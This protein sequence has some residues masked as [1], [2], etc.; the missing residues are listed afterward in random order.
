MTPKERRARLFADSKPI[1]RHAV[2]DDAKWTWVSQELDNWGGVTEGIDRDNW[3]SYAMDRLA[4][5]DQVLVIEDAN[6]QFASG[7]GPVC[8]VSLMSNGWVVEPHSHW[9]AWATPRN[10]LRGTVEFLRL[11]RNSRAVG[12]VHLKCGADDAKWFKRIS[13]RYN[14]LYL[15][16]RIP[17]GQP[18][19]DEYLFYLRGSK[20]DRQPNGQ[21]QERQLFRSRAHRPDAPSV[22]AIQHE[23]RNHTDLG[24]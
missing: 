22:S 4:Q 7:H 15:V 17:H 18:S 16:G 2:L 14:P 9:L 23:R 6:S 1:I 21:Q 11:M 10:K 13:R 8:I 12:V 3:M 5:Y 24:G 19:G 20:R